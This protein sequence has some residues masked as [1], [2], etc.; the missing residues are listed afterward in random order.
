VV[1]Q[2]LDQHEIFLSTE[3]LAELRKHLLGKFKMPGTRVQEIVSFLE[4]QVQLVEPTSVP[5]NSCR[6]PDDGPILG[7]A[8]AALADC[9][10]TGDKDLL[11]LQAFQG[12]PILSPRAFYDH[13]RI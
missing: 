11:D 10:V 8:I 3:I 4:K 1:A 12:I 5:A 9:L 7:T 6:D 2:C 13:S